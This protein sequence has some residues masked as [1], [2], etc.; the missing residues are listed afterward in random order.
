VG[1]VNIWVILPRSITLAL[2]QLL[3]I[4]ILSMLYGFFPL[5][6]YIGGAG[7]RAKHIASPP[8]PYVVGK[9]RGGDEGNKT[10]PGPMLCKKLHIS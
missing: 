8:P 5:F 10:D 1:F 6:L 3:F 7:I 9:A 4:G 2:K